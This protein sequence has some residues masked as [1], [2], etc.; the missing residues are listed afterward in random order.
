MNESG[1]VDVEFFVVQYDPE[2]NIKA[3][4]LEAS[5]SNSTIK[6]GRTAEITA[7]VQP[8]NAT[9]KT[10]TY[11]SSDESVATVSDKGV[12]TAVKPGVA[13]ITV[14]STGGVKKIDVVVEREGEIEQ[15]LE[16]SNEEPLLIV[17]V[18]C[19]RYNAN[20]T[21]MQWGDTLLGRWNSI[22]DDIKPYAIMQIHAGAC[23][24]YTDAVMRFYEQQLDIAEEHGIPCMI[25]TATAGLQPYWTST[26]EITNE[27][28]EEAM[29][30]YDCLKGFIITENY[31][32]DYNKVATAAADHLRIAAENGGYVIWY[33]HQTQVI[34]SILNNPAF[35]KSLAQYNENFAFTWK[36][37]PSGANQNAATSAYMQGLWMNGTIDQWGGLMDTWKWF[38]KQY[39]A[40]FSTSTGYGGGEECR[41]VVMEPEAMLSMEMMS[42]YA[43]GGNIYSFEHPAYTY[44]S[45]DGVTPAFET[46]LDT[47]RYIIDNPAPTKE[48]IIAD[49]G[50]VVHGNLSSRKDLHT[51]VTSADQTLPTHI[52]GRYGLLPAVPASTTLSPELEDLAVRLSDIPSDK[53]GFLN[54]Y[55]PETYT[56]D[57]FAQ[58]VHD[59]WIVYNSNVNKDIDQ[60]A[61]VAVN[62]YNVELDLTPHTMAIMEET[63][64]V[65][66]V[67]LN[68]Y[69]VEKNDIWDGYVAGVT[70]KWNADINTLMQDWI[71]NEYS[72]NPNDGEDTFR[73]TVFTLTDLT[74]EPVVV[75]TTALEDS[76]KEPVVEYD[77]EEGTAVITISSNGYMNF[78][79]QFGEVAVI[80]MEE[81]E[82]AVIEAEA[83]EN[84]NFTDDSWAAFEEALAAAKDL[85]E[86]GAADQAEVD[87]A[88]AELNAAMDALEEKEPEPTPEPWVN[89]FEDVE[90]GKWYYDAVAWGSQNGVVNGL[91]E[92]TFGT[93]VNCTRAQIITFIW[94]AM[95]EPE[96]DSAEYTFKD[97]EEGK[98]YFDAML[99]GVEKG[100]ITGYNADT[101]APE[102]QCTRAQ[103]ATFIWRLAGEPEAEAKDSPFPDVAEGKWYTTAAIWAAENGVVTGYDDGTFGPD[104]DV[105]RSETITMLYRYFVK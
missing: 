74:E 23:E 17:P 15:R 32:T 96:A 5:I 14:R 29:Q 97:V 45:Y 40:L 65:L 6:E 26:S 52:T 9:D 88:V 36:N 34:E 27:W 44:G 38:E 7:K 46:I 78:D 84:E 67:Y 39:Q 95:G 93:K 33:E 75:V 53:L 28:L 77:A 1:C 57:A 66:S 30:K 10:L 20:E 99:W 11:T 54:E 48:E 92:T 98:Y 63:N 49:A 83:I 42:I 104:N 35:K 87:A 51:N 102:D 91:N 43:N 8:F 86:N 19:Q 31:W 47:Y 72:V 2:Y 50:L 100:I 22:P 90:E 55:Y 37:T 59:S 105:L 4:E 13:T 24:Y 89:P 12:V 69:R 18:Y 25:V 61:L 56:G 101:F 82:A 80:E 71:Q 81:L 73:D 76:Y 85:L 94:R 3:T 103:M 79:I 58:K 68:N 60:S 21:E 64:D 62:D 70:Q 16:I 41:A